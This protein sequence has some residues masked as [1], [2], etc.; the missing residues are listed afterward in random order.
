MP[1]AIV[2]MRQTPG[3]D[4]QKG[5][6]SV[7][8]KLRSTHSRQGVQRHDR[9]GGN[10]T[11]IRPDSVTAMMAIHPKARLAHGGGRRE[12][13]CR[14]KPAVENARPS[15]SSRLTIAEGPSGPRGGLKP[16]KSSAPARRPSV[17]VR[18][19]IHTVCPRCREFAKTHRRFDE[20]RIPPDLAALSEM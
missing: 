20:T 1:R 11:W 9:G 2:T 8:A 13:T 19:S 5:G 15:G 14:M 12:S 7:I 6:G 4:L 17:T 16:S 18:R 3:H 10:I